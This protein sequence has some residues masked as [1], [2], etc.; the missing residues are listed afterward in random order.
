M[1]GCMAHSPARVLLLPR[2]AGVAHQAWSAPRLAGWA[3][4]RDRLAR[5]GRL[6]AQD[7]LTYYR[8]STVDW[9]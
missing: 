8:A 1:V 7:G 6:W 4:H 9:T 3:A 2:L 5:L